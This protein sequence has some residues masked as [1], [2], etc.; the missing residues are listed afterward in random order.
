MVDKKLYKQTLKDH[1]NNET[2]CQNI[3]PE[4]K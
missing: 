2:F 1:A 3:F 4:I